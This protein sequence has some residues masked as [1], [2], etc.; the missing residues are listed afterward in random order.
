MINDVEQY[1]RLTKIVTGAADAPAGLTFWIQCQP[2]SGMCVWSDC[3]RADWLFWIAK[4]VGVASALIEEAEAFVVARVKE[5]ALQ[6]GDEYAPLSTAASAV[7][8]KIAWADVLYG[9]GSDSGAVTSAW[10]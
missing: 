7:R 5:V 4:R 6:D 9:V 1:E 8:V 2:R 10:S 3:P